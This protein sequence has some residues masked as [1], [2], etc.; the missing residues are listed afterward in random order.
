MYDKGGLGPTALFVGMALLRAQPYPSTRCH[1]DRRGGRATLKSP[2]ASLIAKPSSAT[3]V[4]RATSGPSAS[5]RGC[6]YPNLARTSPRMA[7]QP[8]LA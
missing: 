7:R 5:A 4:D 6:Y 3:M 8:R 2:P 1:V